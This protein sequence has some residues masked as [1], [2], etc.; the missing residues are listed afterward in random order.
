[1]AQVLLALGASGGAVSTI[2]TIAS[3]AAP[4]LGVVG[5]ISQIKAAKEQEAELERQG[6][7]QRIMAS[8]EAERARR[9]AR[10]RQSRDRTAMLE[11][12]AL[13]GTAEGVLEQNAVA[14]ELDALTVEFRG[15]QQQ[16]AS[17]FAA[18]QAGRRVGV[19]D[20]FSS[21]ISGFSQVDPLN[22]SN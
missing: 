7:E 14:Q 22:I 15:E 9:E 10:F 12:G 4:V 16:R 11:G 18:R 19:L 21:A 2:S 17:Q 13:S 6:K 3:I 1:M 20:V 8:V 5:T